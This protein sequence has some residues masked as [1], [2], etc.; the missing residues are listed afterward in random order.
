[1][2]CARPVRWATE[3]RGR[4]PAGLEVELRQ[5]EL[6][7]TLERGERDR[8]VLDGEAGGVERGDLVV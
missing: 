1:M 6:A 5:V 8:E 4:S 7:C 2:P 3:P